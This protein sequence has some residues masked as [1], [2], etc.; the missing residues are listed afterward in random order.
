MRN[1]DQEEPELPPTYAEL[2]LDLAYSRSVIQ[3]AESII[4]GHK[5]RIEALEADV[6][7]LESKA[8]D[9]SEQGWGT[10]DEDRLFEGRPKS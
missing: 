2:Q 4:K 1:K 6:K 7:W 3:Y 10:Y 8:I 9:L 5:Q